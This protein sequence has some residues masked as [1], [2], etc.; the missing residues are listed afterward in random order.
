[1]YFIERGN[2]RILVTGEMEEG[3]GGVS[4]GRGPLCVVFGGLFAQEHASFTNFLIALVSRQ[5]YIARHKKHIHV[6]K[7]KHGHF[8]EHGEIKGRLASMGRSYTGLVCAPSAEA[9]PLQSNYWHSSDMLTEKET[10]LDLISINF[11]LK[12]NFAR[13]TL[14]SSRLKYFSYLFIPFCKMRPV[15]TSVWPVNRPFTAG[16]IESAPHSAEQTSQ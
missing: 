13:S 6:L 15:N 3:G 7:T 14:C 11:S 2:L 4:G 12:S 10:I 1:M 8:L 9:G 5:E 16:P